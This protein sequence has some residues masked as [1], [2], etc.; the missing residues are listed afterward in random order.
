[1]GGGFSNQ[2]S[3]QAWTRVCSKTT[4]RLFQKAAKQKLSRQSHI[5]LGQS[6]RVKI[7]KDIYKP[8]ILALGVK[9]ASS[10]RKLAWKLLDILRGVAPHSRCALCMLRGSATPQVVNSC[11]DCSYAHNGFSA[12]RGHM[13]DQGYKYIYKAI[14][15]KF[16]SGFSWLL[17][18][19]FPFIE[20][21][22]ENNFV[23]WCCIIFIFSWSWKIAVF[24]AVFFFFFFF[25]WTR[26]GKWKKGRRQHARFGQF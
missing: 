14:Q 7:S 1:M 15:T 10:I 16:L 3:R 17:S 18:G 25:Q 13:Q 2:R 9:K 5:L 8:F 11:Q 26:K 21:G 23:S 20:V 22:F 4:W 6:C 12:L 24:G 19:K